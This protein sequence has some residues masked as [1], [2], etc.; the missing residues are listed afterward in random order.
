MFFP[1]AEETLKEYA[2]LLRKLGREN[3]AKDLE[4]KIKS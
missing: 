1:K 3:E 2:A 4:S